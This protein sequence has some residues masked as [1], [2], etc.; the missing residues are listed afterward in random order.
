MR[1]EEGKRERG[2]KGKNW[3]KKIGRRKENHDTDLSSRSASKTFSA[4]EFLP[5]RKTVQHKRGNE[6][7]GKEEKSTVESRFNGTIKEE[8]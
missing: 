5:N 7:W 2:G 4:I 8:D 6:F 3:G 1:G